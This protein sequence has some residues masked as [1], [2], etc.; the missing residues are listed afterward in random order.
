MPAFGGGG[1]LQLPVTLDCVVTSG[2][3]HE[4]ALVRGGTEPNSATHK[5]CDP[6]KLP[7]LS[8]HLCHRAVLKHSE[9]RDT[10]NA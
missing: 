3:E 6:S 10:V 8:E 4:L 2:Q 7:D 5:L 9:S 1:V